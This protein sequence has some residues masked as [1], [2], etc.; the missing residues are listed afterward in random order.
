VHKEIR[1]T[2]FSITQSWPLLGI[3]LSIMLLMMSG[4]TAG[5]ADPALA[6]SPPVFQPN[7]IQ[8]GFAEYDTPPDFSSDAVFIF[9]INVFLILLLI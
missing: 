2:H 5:A 9:P 7:E 8:H 3:L 6:D 1:K 4:T